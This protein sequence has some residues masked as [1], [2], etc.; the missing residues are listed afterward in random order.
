MEALTIGF[1]E[2]FYDLG[3][4]LGK[5]GFGKVILGMDKESGEEVAIK[6]IPRN[7]C[8]DSVVSEC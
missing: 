2:D 6:L 7:K 3:H 4:L 5:G 8:D 1:L